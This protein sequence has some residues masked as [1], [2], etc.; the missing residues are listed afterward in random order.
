MPMRWLTGPSGMDVVDL[1]ED[2]D[3]EAEA[4]DAAPET[5]AEAAAEPNGNGEDTLP[6]DGPRLGHR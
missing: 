6:R 3:T 1:D 4:T 2:G 5:A